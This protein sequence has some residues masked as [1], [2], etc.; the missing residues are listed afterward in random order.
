MSETEAT[1]PTRGRTEKKGV[2]TPKRSSKVNASQ[3]SDNP[4]FFKRI[5]LFV[6][7]VIQELKKVTYPTGK[8]TWT[9]FVVVTVF[10]A[11]IMAIAGLLDLGFGTLSAYVFG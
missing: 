4:G 7:Q 10:V 1:E 6:S 9:Y 5:I 3:Q 11:S 8:E 2:A